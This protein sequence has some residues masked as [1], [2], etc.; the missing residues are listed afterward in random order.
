[1]PTPLSTFVPASNAHSGESFAGSRTCWKVGPD[2]NGGQPLRFPRC[3][4]CGSM[5]PQLFIELLESGKAKAD[6][7]DW[8]YGYPHKVYVT[9]P[10]PDPE[11]LREC[12]STSEG[13][14]MIYD[15]EGRV[16]HREKTQEQA[17]ERFPEWSDRCGWHEKSPYPTLHLKFYTAHLLDLHADDLARHAEL[18]AQHTGILFERE[19]ERLKY[20][21]SSHRRTV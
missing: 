19:G 8:K 17:P 6:V 11:E 9:T 3:T 2:D 15:R 13:S 12:S 7:A 21:C 20:R 4:W 5:S 1:M 16:T 14:K 10:N 18:I